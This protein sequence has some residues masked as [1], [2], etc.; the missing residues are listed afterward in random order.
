RIQKQ[1]HEDM[2]YTAYSGV[3]VQRDLTKRYGDASVSAPV[4]F[5]CNL[6]T[7]LVNE[8]FKETLGDFSYMISQTPQVWNDFQSYED[9][10]GVQL[11]WDSVDALFP[12]TMV[13][14]MIKS[15]E[16]L[17]HQLTEKGWYQ[18]FDLLP[19]SRRKALVEMCRTG[20]PE[21]PQCL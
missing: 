17:L 19:E 2:K 4:V 8:G 3:Q 20:V 7:P 14:D 18:R 15:F 6:G 21:K 16:T 12:E 13:D 10:N 11:T 1:L 5:A 9:E